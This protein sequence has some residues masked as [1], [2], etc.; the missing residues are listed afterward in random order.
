MHSQSPQ[1][2]PV[3]I[4]AGLPISGSHEGGFGAR[5]R[6]HHLSRP[7]RRRDISRDAMW[8]RV[9]HRLSEVVDHAEAVVSDVQRVSA[10]SGDAGE[11]PSEGRPCA[12]RHSTHQRDQPDQS[13]TLPD[14]SARGGGAAGLLD[15]SDPAEGGKSNGESVE[16]LPSRRLGL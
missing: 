12:G 16:T 5:P 15:R 9:P 7:E 3:Q 8:S 13:A 1:L 10:A 4:E 6:L 11:R 14:C 2:L